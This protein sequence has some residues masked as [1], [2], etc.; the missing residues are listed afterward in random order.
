MGLSHQKQPALHLTYGDD[1]SFADRESLAGELR[2]Q[3]LENCGMETDQQACNMETD[4]WCIVNPFDGPS[5][6][7]F[8]PTNGG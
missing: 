3:W 6:L 8:G 7:W 2:Q 5:D 4:I 1:G